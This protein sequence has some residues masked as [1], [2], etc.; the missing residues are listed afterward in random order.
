[1]GR[2][3]IARPVLVQEFSRVF[4]RGTFEAEMVHSILI[5][6][7]DDPQLGRGPSQD[8]SSRPTDHDE[9]H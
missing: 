3:K 7:K 6:D 2:P 9:S 8:D 1:M 4:I 5:W